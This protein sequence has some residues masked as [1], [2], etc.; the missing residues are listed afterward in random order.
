MG[1]LLFRR[2]SDFDGEQRFPQRP[3]LCSALLHFSLEIVNRLFCPT[4]LAS[5][6]QPGMLSLASGVDPA[7]VPGN[8]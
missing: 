3:R 2:R 5:W 4:S 1:P 8:L 7:I 6:I